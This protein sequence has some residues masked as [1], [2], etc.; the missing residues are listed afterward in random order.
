VPQGACR[1]GRAAGG[2]PPPKPPA[3]K[4][5]PFSFFCFITTSA[6]RME[7]IITTSAKRMEQIITTSAKRMEQIVT[8]SANKIKTY[9]TKS[10]TTP[11]NIFRVVTTTVRNITRI[12]DHSNI[13]FHTTRKQ[14]SSNSYKFLNRHKTSYNM[15]HI[16]KNLQEAENKLGAPQSIIGPK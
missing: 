5:A 15:F 1:R 2:V 10:L 14:S 16:I 4:I 12:S 6:K 8:M 3:G 13:I 9:K 11:N 7:Q